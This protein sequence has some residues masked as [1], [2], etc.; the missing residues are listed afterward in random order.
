MKKAGFLLAVAVL[1]FIA[2]FQGL[3]CSE[4][5]EFP[6]KTH[7]VSAPV[8]NA[9]TTGQVPETGEEDTGR[10]IICNS[11]SSYAYHA[12]LCRGLKK[13]RAGTRTISM[14]EARNGGYKPCGNCYR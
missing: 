12:R 13:C 3:N 1:V 9:D 4:T 2:L 14:K 5:K 8:M 11:R 7:P 10:V 6:R